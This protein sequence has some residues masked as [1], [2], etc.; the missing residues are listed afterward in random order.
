MGIKVIHDNIYVTTRNGIV[1]LRDLNGD[2]ETDFYENFYSDHDVSSFFHAFNFGL[3][4]DSKGNFY[5][6]KVG[7]YTDN[8]DPG[9]VIR[10]SPDGKN[11]ES[12]ATGFRVNNGITISPDDRIFV[13][14]NQGNWEPANKIC[15]IKKNAFYGYVPNLISE[16]E[17]SPDGKK[18][19][20]DQLIEGVIRPDIVPVPDSFEQPAFWIPQ[21]FDNS[22]GGGVWSDQAWGP[23]G[24]Q[25]I[26][27]SYGTG[28][29]YYFL[30]QETA[31]ITQGAMVA[32]PFQLPA[33]VQRAA[34]NPV[35]KQVYVTGLTGWDDPEA[36]SYGVLSRIRYKGG[37]GHLIRDAK[38]VEGGIRLDFNFPLNDTA[39][40]NP[41]RYDLSA[42]NYQWTSHYG[43][44]H[45][46]IREAGKTGEDKLTVKEVTL[47]N[48]GQSIILNIPDL[49]PA[50]T[51]RL[52][53]DVE[54][55]DGIEVRNSVYLTILK[56]PK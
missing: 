8:K 26:H 14:D 35:D 19:G 53:F 55:A 16:N 10:V 13:T 17:W 46:S 38:V 27:T 24:N 29:V 25:F 34:V 30:P 44:D 43:S 3:E 28:W 18:F 47:Q 21:E 12:I 36:V 2:G 40:K 5:Y 9:N 42:W 4:T 32:L 6:T 51:L 7:E 56:M 15:L 50:Q 49:G 20:K 37:N 11:W 41:L 39:A 54:A 1:L 45:Y 52:R 48:S 31:G 22:P 33:G 23:L